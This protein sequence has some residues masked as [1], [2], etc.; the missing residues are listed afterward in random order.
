MKAFAIAMFIL[1]LNSSF[2][3]VNYTGIVAVEKQPYEEWISN[4][5]A[6]EIAQESYADTLVTE[7][8][9]SFGFGDF[10]SGFFTFIKV[11]GYVVFGLQFTLAKMG[12]PYPLNYFIS[13]P[14]YAAYL[15]ALA[16]MISG[17]TTKTMD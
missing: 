10:V 15:V 4:V 7:E 8:T 13:I 6:D 14:M 11:I 3:V 12:L 1:I 16:Q 5:G 2:L 9:S 17:R